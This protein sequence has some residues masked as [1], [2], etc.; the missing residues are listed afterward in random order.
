MLAGV[1]VRLRFVK[2]LAAKVEEPTASKL[3]RAIKDKT[4]VVNL[5][6]DDRERLLRAMESA[7]A[8]LAELRGV[9]LAEHYA[10]ARGDTA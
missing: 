6:I 1:S 8:E 7:P 4:V 2:Q 10:R 5:D 3:T 9:L